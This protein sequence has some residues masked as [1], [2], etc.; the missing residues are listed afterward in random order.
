MQPLR[1]FCSYSHRDKALWQEFKAH[2]APMERA[3]RIEVWFDGM[4]EAGQRWEETIYRK[5]DTADIILVL[6]S[7][8][9]V[10]SEFCYSKELKRATER[11]A[12]GK[13]QFRISSR[14][15]NDPLPLLSVHACR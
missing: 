4:I 1:V 10:E 8:Y 6:V 14:L 15:E 12:E 3:G 2:L 13:V 11:D 9:F 7:A 5:L